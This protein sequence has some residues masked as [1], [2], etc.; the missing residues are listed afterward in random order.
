M[1]CSLFNNTLP[2]KPAG[3]LAAALPKH[4]LM[5]LTAAHPDAHQL[6]DAADSSSS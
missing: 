3:C 2:L 5:R 4:Q 6:I 1:I